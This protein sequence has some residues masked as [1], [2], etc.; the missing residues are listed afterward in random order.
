MQGGAIIINLKNTSNI[1]RQ[2]VVEYVLGKL[3]DSLQTGNSKPFSSSPKKPTCTCAKPTGTTSSPACGTS[4]SSPHS[5]PTSLTPFKKPST[6]K[7]TTFSSS[8]S[9]TNTTWTSSAE[10]HAW[11]LKPCG[12]SPE[13]CRRITASLL[14]KLSATSQ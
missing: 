3:V 11:T 12:Q 2:I 6:A 14:A 13:T 9:P 7:P 1:D 8:T 10:P 4:A 5:S